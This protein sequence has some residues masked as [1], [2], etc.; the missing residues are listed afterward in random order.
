MFYGVIY[1]IKVAQCFLKHSV[2]VSYR[3]ILEC[4]IWLRRV[5]VVG[6]QSEQ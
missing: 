3:P 1:K 2:V 5:L 4:V 6:L